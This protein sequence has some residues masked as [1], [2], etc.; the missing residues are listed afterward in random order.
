MN[1]YYMNKENSQEEKEDNLHKKVLKVS[2][3]IGSSESIT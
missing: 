3:K 1:S 2:N